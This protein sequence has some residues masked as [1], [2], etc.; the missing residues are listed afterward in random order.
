MKQM[1]WLGAVVFYV[2]AG[3]NHFWHPHFYYPLIPDYLPGKTTLNIGSGL[4]EIA[5]GVLLIFPR[6]RLWAC[7]GIV[8]LL[9]AFVPAHVHFI[10]QGS[11]VAEGLC[12]PAW[13]GWV[14]LVVVHPLL[15]AWA[16]WIRK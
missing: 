7:Y 6:T 5:L 9:V 2:V 15:M 14:R 4:A 8:A 1:A 16:W 13:V 3:I 10:Q 12:V 11:C